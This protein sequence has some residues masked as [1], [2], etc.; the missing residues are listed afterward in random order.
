MN[1]DG[2]LLFTLTSIT[3]VS[4]GITL[5]LMGISRAEYNNE[6]IFYIIT[7]GILLCF[8]ILILGMSIYLSNIG[9][10]KRC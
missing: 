9:R 8:S 2:Y 7:C 1:R 3:T 4:I 6:Y 5:I 10:R